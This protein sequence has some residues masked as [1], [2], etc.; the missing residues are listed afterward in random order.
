MILQSTRFDP[1][2]IIEQY[3]ICNIISLVDLGSLDAFSAALKLICI[4]S[5][6]DKDFGYIN[7]CLHTILLFAVCRE[8]ADMVKIL[9]KRGVSMNL[10][11]DSSNPL[12]IDINFGI[13]FD[14]DLDI[15]HIQLLVLAVLCNNTEIMSSLLQ[16]GV[17]VNRPTKVNGQ[18]CTSLDVARFMGL[19]K[20]AD[21]LERAGGHENASALVNV[22]RISNTLCQTLSLFPLEKFVSLVKQFQSMHGIRHQ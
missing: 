5:I 10:N 21:M 17:D 11:H 13:V 22:P 14:T 2:S 19:A 16:Y 7:D 12:L 1:W 8:N 6:T 3:R 9:L 18:Q 20:M 4:P 15:C